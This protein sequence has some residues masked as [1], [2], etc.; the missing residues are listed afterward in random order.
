MTRTSRL[1]LTLR[2]SASQ[3]AKPEDDQERLGRFSA[4]LWSTV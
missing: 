2:S 4:G 1:N 3:C